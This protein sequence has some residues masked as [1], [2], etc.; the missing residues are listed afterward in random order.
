M[1]PAREI[2]LQKHMH[3]EDMEFERIDAFKYLCVETNAR[4]SKHMDI[5]VK[6]LAVR[7]C[8]NAWKTIIKFKLMSVRSDHI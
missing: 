2:S 5:R 7:Y 4:R 8:F 6:I 3:V 1:K